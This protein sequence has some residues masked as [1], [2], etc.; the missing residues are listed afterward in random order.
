M[1]SDSKFPHE[2]RPYWPAGILPHVTAIAHA[3]QTTRPNRST[4]TAKLALITAGLALLVPSITGCFNGMN[5]S[6]NVQST[7]AP[8]TGVQ[9]MIGT[10]SIDNATLVTGPGT[11]GTLL[12]RIA[13]FGPI[14]D[15]LV[16]AQING[17]PAEIV[18]TSVEI[19]ANESIPF[20]WESV[21]YVNTIALN[22]GP[23][24]YVPVTLQFE[25][26]GVVDMQVLT[27]PPA[28]VYEGIAPGGL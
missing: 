19:P 1:T 16:Q 22:V 10:L 26:S 7:T 9:A 3:P 23:S 27:V 2:S 28:G 17:Q 24:T 14:G 25:K 13:N 21:H 6:T 18:G 8:G 5:A 20:G 11:T 4:S 15:T 12:M